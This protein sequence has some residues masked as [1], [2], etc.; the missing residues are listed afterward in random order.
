MALASQSNRTNRTTST[1]DRRGVPTPLIAVAA[2]MLALGGAY[3]LIELGRAKEAEPTASAVMDAPVLAST[4][5]LAPAGTLTAGEPT[6]RDAE[7]VPTNAATDAATIAAPTTPT[8]PA[9]SEEP[10]AIP[11]KPAAALAAVVPTIVPTAALQE[12]PPAT[13]PAPAGNGFDAAPAP[14]QPAATAASGAAAELARGL[15]LAANDPIAARTA[16]SNA[17]LAGT[18]TE[19]EA[20]QA[21]D[22]LNEISRRLVFTPSANANDTM[23]FTHTIASGESLERIVRKYKPGCDWRF[24]QRINGIKKPEAI[25]VGQRIK[26]PK[27]P[28]SAMVSKRDYR[29]DICLGAGSERVVIACLPVGLGSENGT[30]VGRFRV[31]PGS[32]LIDPEWRHPHTGE[33]FASN[34]PKNPIGEHWLGLEGTEQATSQLAGYGIHGTIDIDSI[35]HNRSLGCVRLLA[36]DVALAWEAL[37]DGAEV[38]IRA[39]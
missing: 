9:P 27:G 35:G 8:T 25:R 34:D 31:K 16:L 26:I 3:W 29:L 28:F 10:P 21:A 1:R 12:T 23:F 37:G 33:Y 39:N 14:A 2:S 18:L 13:K 7:S 22:M 5:P 20:K 15:S 6:P 32:K 30:P 24:V 19:P 36:D 38:E 11:A 17:L 4:A